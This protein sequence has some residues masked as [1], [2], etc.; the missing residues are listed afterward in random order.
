MLGIRRTEDA[1]ELDAIVECSS[2]TYVRALARDLGATLGIGGHLAALRR[3]TVGPFDLR[4]VTT[5]DRL[6]DAP[7]LSLSMD[8][9]VDKAFPRR[10]VDARSAAGGRGRRG[11]RTS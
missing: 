6:A 5:L 3:T 4:V 7:G 10:D 8:D 11:R 1:I 9:A 2:G